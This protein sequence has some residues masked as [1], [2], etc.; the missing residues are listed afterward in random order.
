MCIL[1]QSGYQSVGYIRL[2][3]SLYFCVF[4]SRL[5]PMKSALFIKIPRVLLAFTVSV[6]MAGGCLFGCSNMQAMGAEPVESN[7]TV[8]DGESCEPAGGHSCCTKPK[9]KASGRVKIVSAR[10]DAPAANQ[11]A[12]L[13]SAPRGMK[14]CPLMANTT[15]ATSKNSGN[16][17]EPGR[18][19]VAVL[20]R[21]HSQIEQAQVVTTSSYRPN[22]GPTHLRCCVFLI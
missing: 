19:A 21:I 17:P 5:L 13:K 18:T 11:G 22:R 7:A 1:R 16:L 14:D 12:T 4:R 2:A 15:A 9:T 10:K 3:R 6:W 20:P 8:V